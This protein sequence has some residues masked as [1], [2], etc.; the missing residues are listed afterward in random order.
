MSLSFFFH[1]CVNNYLLH[2][3]L[4]FIACISLIYCM[5]YSH[6]LRVL[7]SFI[8]CI[9]IVYYVYYYR[10]LR[11]LLSFSTCTTIVYC[12]YFYHLLHVFL[13][14]SLC[15]LGHLESTVP[16]PCFHAFLLC[17]AW[18]TFV[19]QVLHIPRAC[20]C[21]HC[22]A[23]RCFYCT[24]RRFSV[25]QGVSVASFAHSPCVQVFLLHHWHIPP[26]AWRRAGVPIQTS[27][28]PN[29]PSRAWRRGS[30]RAHRFH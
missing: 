18:R 16:S 29:I 5:Y 13:L 3:L 21:L 30:V 8:T 2:V 17:N 1:D 10:L 11:V 6:L 22:V 24:I 7:L 14:L 25:P 12:T 19:L 27:C 23:C 4:S 15:W 28:H 20:R 26:R 9:T